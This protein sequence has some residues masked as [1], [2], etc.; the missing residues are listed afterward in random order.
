MR[1]VLFILKCLVGIFAT[2]GLIVIGL[3]AFGFWAGDSLKD[4]WSETEEMPESAVLQL[5]LGAGISEAPSDPFAR[6][7]F[8]SA[9]SLRDTVDAIETAAGDQRVKSLYA[10]LGSGALTLSQAQ[11]LRAAILGFKE[12]GKPAIAFAETFGE[13]GD[14]TVHYYLASAFDEVWVQPSGEVSVTGFS[15]QSPYLR[16][17]L[18]DLGILPRLAQREEYKGFANTFTDGEMP[19]PVRENLSQLAQSWLT[20][21]ASEVSA[22]R[23]LQQEEVLRAIDRAPLSAGEAKTA[24][25][26]DELGY[27]D[28]VRSAITA[29]AGPDARFYRL[30]DYART[31]SEET[32]K[33]EEG[34]AIAVITGAGAVTLGNGEGGGFGG[35]AI[36]T[37]DRIVRAFDEAVK[38]EE[39]KAI[40]FRIDSPGGSYVAADAIWRA[41]QQAQT[42]GKPVI[43]SM[44]S[45]AAS[46]GYFAALP[47]DR[48]VA[49]PATVTGSIGV[50]S[51]KMVFTELLD[52]LGIAVEGPQAGANAG[53]W[54]GTE[55]F[56]EAQWEQLQQSLDR[57][58]ADFTG[59]VAAGRDMDI[60]S[61]LEV[62]GGRVWTGK[63]ALDAGL[64][65]S[66]GGFKTAVAEARAAAELGDEV[67]TRL[68]D[69][70]KEDD[71]FSAA[72]SDLFGIRAS[73]KASRDLVRILR[74]AAPVL[75]TVQE[76]RRDP[77]ETTL[78]LPREF[79]PAEN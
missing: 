41:V 14:G 67:E 7:G 25:L 1:I 55:D 19:E 15:M 17:A 6:F 64:V 35:E 16:E 65:D 54:S 34:P 24:R 50:V 31:L 28:Q 74:L 48:I 46:G 26:I 68:V 53:Y 20:Q 11:E 18:D 51:G 61:V 47:A 70:P 2:V 62:A 29:E 52:D 71:P 57:I 33:V 40:V 39:V 3:V 75:E 27:Q 13:G 21:V 5:D 77:R 12:S 36:M 76:L 44:S 56:T 58:Y 30:R 59:K 45:V 38:D 42:A 8:D 73:A 37:S 79:R 60:D 32:P 23:A 69:Y 43:V 49:L 72:L 63:D 22:G 9:L 10:H 4:T 78:M 66:L